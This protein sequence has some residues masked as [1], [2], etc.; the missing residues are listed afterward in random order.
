MKES[1]VTV[2]DLVQIRSDLTDLKETVHTLRETQGDI[3]SDVASIK[4]EQSEIRSNLKGARRLAKI[5]ALVGPLIMG[6]LAFYVESKTESKVLEMRVPQM[7]ASV[8]SLKDTMTRLENVINTKFHTY[9]ATW[10]K[11]LQ[12]EWWQVKSMVQMF[13]DHQQRPHAG[14]ASQKQFAIIERKLRELEEQLRKANRQRQ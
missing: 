7:Q 2:A 14:S 6:G 9:D 3:E 1:E 5:S 10:Q 12:D 8:E 13:E 4:V 11:F